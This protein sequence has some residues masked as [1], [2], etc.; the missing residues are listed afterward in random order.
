MKYPPQLES[1][2]RWK[3]NSPTTVDVF[4]VICAR[5]QRWSAMVNETYEDQTP[6]DD[7]RSS[8]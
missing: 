2:Q 5:K 6:K 8:L 4:S 3:G 1:G 7:A